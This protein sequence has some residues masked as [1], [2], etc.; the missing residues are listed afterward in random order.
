MIKSSWIRFAGLAIALWAVAAVAAVGVQPAEAAFQPTEESTSLTQ[1]GAPST[2]AGAHPDLEVRLHFP[3]RPGVNGELVNDG[4]VRDIKVALPPGLVGNAA[5]F[6]S[7]SVPDLSGT[8]FAECAT[9]AQVGIVKL[10]ALAPGGEF[11]TWEEV[12]LYNME[13]PA[14][15]PAELAFNF[16]GDIVRIEAGV[17]PDD[18]GITTAAVRIPTALPLIDLRVDIWG[19][20]ADRSHDPDRWRI[21]LN[22]GVFERGIQ[23]PARPLPFLSNPTSCPAAP[24]KFGI[25]ADSWEETGSFSSTVLETDEEGHPFVMQ[26][27]ERLPFAPKATVDPTSGRAGSTAGLDLHIELPQ[28]Q[29]PNGLATANVKDTVVTLPQGFAISASAAGG[30]GTCSEAQIGLGSNAAPTCPDSSRLGTVEIKSP[31]LAEPLDGSVYLAQQKANPFGSNYALYLVAQGPGF[32]IKLPGK[33]EADAATGQVTASFANQPQLPYESIDVH[34]RGGAG[35]PLVTP[36]ACGTYQAQV[37]M[38]SWASPTPVQLGSPMKIDEGCSAGGFSPDLKAG[39]ANPSGGSYSPFTLRVT[40]QE[41]EANLARIQATLPPGLLAKLAGVPLCGDTQAATGA[42]PAASQVGTTTIGAGPG[43][44]PIY[45]PEAGKAPT[46]VFLGGPYKGAPYSLIAKVPAQAGPFDLGTVV[47]RSAL[48]VDPFTT[49]VTAQ[50]DPL[51]QILEGIPITYRDVRLEV[52]RPDF[53]INPTNCSQF[54]VAGLLTSAGGRTATPQ[55][56]F[57]AAS[58]ERLEFKP[59]LQVRLSGSTKR[60]GHPALKAVLTYPT[61]GSFANIARAQ[62]NLPR[63]EF[64]DQGNLD[65]TCTKPALLAGS[66]PASSIYGTARAWSPLLDQPL[67]G[68]VYLVGGFGYKL[69]ALVADL[70]GQIHVILKSRIDS[71]SNKGL[72]A[73]FEAVPDAPVSRFVLQ[74]KGGKKYGLLVNSENVCGRPQKLKAAFTAQNG[75]THDFNQ[76]IRVRCNGRASK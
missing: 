12:A 25:E 33:V 44:N 19:V 40:G 11:S 67:A 10:R 14:D 36:S 26:G 8:F 24:L 66:C 37:Q 62:V 45:L 20:P 2:Q 70:N 21:N 57:A 52:N 69:P 22:E 61:K 31:L 35:A 34:L 18:Y 43:P 56:P 29:G 46:A 65:K 4:T 55:A 76:K 27:C 71:G 42:C 63:A 23:S 3:D 59:R 1:G 53:T 13:A 16:L 72:R 32:Y 48:Q 47:V 54:A 6:E 74:M 50:S 28:P 41:G 9:G 60:T 51:P 30:Q 75:K 73:T 68:P 58:C 38:T 49:Q 39:T 5:N 7:C 64:L 15:P 17:R